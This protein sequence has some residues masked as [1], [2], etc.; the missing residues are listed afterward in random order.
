LRLWRA[1]VFLLALE[2]SGEFGALIRGDEV[3]VGVDGGLPAGFDGLDGTEVVAG[4][5]AVG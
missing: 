5:E 4:I 1:M 3:D 2:Q